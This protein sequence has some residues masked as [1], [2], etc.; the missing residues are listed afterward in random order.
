[1][2]AV[3]GDVLAD[4]CPP[5]SGRS[6]REVFLAGAE[7]PSVCP[8][9][10]IGWW[11][12]VQGWFGSGSPYPMAEATPTPMLEALPSLPPDVESL[13]MGGEPTEGESGTAPDLTPYAPSRE[14]QA[15]PGPEPGGHELPP[16]QPS[17]APVPAPPAPATPPRV[18]PPR[19]LPP[20]QPAGTAPPE[21]PAEPSEPEPAPQPTATPPLFHVSHAAAH[22]LL[23]PR[24]VP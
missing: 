15:E 9:G 23:R 2:D 16:V 20:V 8:S 10:G 19:T 5:A 4:G 22:G 13:P 24:H 14:G 21:E 1:V 6:Y 12:R 17:I 11:Q 7:P 18:R 3:T